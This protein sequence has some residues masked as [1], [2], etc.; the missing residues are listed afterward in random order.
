VHRVG[1]SWIPSREDENTD[2]AP[3]APQLDVHRASCAHL[4]AAGQDVVDEGKI[5]L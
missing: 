5:A 3:R 1:W 4:N 2:G